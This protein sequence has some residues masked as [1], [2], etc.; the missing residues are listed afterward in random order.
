VTRDARSLALAAAGASALVVTGY[1]LAAQ[2]LLAAGA[3]LGIAV[4][5]ATLAWP[6][7]IVALM[8]ALGPI[9]LSVLT[10]GARGL[11]PALGG[12]DMSGIRLIA[13]SGGLGMV[14]LTRRDLLEQLGGPLARWYTLFL[15]WATASLAFSPAPL[16]GLRL[17]LKLAY[18]LLVYLV[19]A[20]PERTPAELRRLG[21]WALWGATAVLLVN[22]LFVANGAYAVEQGQTEGWLRVW[23]PGSHHNPFS[24]YL[25]AVLMLCIAR[26]RARGESRYLL[27]GGVAIAWLALTVTRIT[28]LASL[29]ALAVV[30]VYTALVDRNRRALV[31]IVVSGVLVCSLLLEG[32]LVRTFGYLPTASELLA[33]A[34]DPVALYQ[35]VNWQGRESLW[36]ILLLVFRENPV[37]GSGLGA[38]S[39]YL[40]GQVEQGGVAHNEYLRLA[41]DTGVLGCALYFL[42]VVGWIRGAARAVRARAPFA[43]EYAMPMLALA[44]AWAV[45]AATDNAFDY[46]GP[47]TQY[48][49]FLAGACAVIAR[50]AEAPVEPPARAPAP[51]P[52]TLPIGLAPSELG[53]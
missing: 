14:V 23:G 42:A 46:Y 31:V 37:L 41:V 13:I 26:F 35:A 28:F 17:L 11:L 51:D 40:V 36:A 53:R 33:L 3:V 5:S 2:P 1:G 7:M 4:I 10:G 43:E 8:L 21:N 29:V 52:V 22:P 12:L 27:L 9:D 32:V 24:F 38:S 25:L 30:A 16:D 20:A 34:R 6:L 48:V 49:A 47:F 18:P 50:P 45:I 19:V 44:A 15:A 39:A